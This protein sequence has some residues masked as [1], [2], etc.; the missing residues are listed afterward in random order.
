MLNLFVLWASAEQTRSQELESREQCRASLAKAHDM[1]PWQ[2][3]SWS[4][5]TFDKMPPCPAEC[6]VFQVA[7]A[8]QSQGREFGQGI[9]QTR[10]QPLRLAQSVRARWV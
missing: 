4:L 1:V 8:S 3:V 7:N 10:M 2:I 9:C 6:Q 5:R